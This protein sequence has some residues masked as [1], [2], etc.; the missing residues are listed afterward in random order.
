MNAF[1]R[2]GGTSIPA[3]TIN[4]LVLWPPV[5]NLE[6]EVSSMPWNFQKDVLPDKNRKTDNNRGDHSR[7]ETK[8]SI[9]NRYSSR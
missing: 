1:E 2:Q 7:A 8:K 9:T 5:T 6:L 4:V 3:S